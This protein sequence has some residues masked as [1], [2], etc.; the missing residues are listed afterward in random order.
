MMASI[1]L[2]HLPTGAEL[3]LEQAPSC[4]IALGN[5]D[6]VHTA[7]RMLLAAAVRLSKQK[8]DCHSA[9]FFFD[10]PSSQV[11]FTG[12]RLLS[13][14]P[15]KLAIF[16]EA[17]IEY[18]YLAD[19]LSLRN[20]PADPFIE[21]VLL[22]ICHADKVVCGFNFRFGQGGKGNVTLLEQR[23]GTQNIRTLPPCCMPI[24]GHR[25]EHVIS[26]TAVR[27]ALACGDVRA[28]RLLLGRPYRFSAPVLH[29]KQLGR[30]LGIPTINQ[31]PP[32]GKV[33]PT[34][35]VYIT[36]VTIGNE[37]VFGISNVG[38]H[39]TVD[40][41]A[42]Q[43][44]ETHLLNFEG[45]LYGQTI[46]VEFLEMLRQEQKFDSVEQLQKT[47]LGDIEKAKQYFGIE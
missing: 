20:M 3:P 27:N 46:T 38:I 7:H 23:L 5:F 43:N 6:G 28:A 8:A 29:G 34:N 9:V 42:E 2:I 47:I 19:F 13:T 45:D 14:L 17:G 26:S 40:D 36:Q 22:D 10:P 32:L 33:L 12:T 24:P 21:E 44:C 25:A 39:P 37:K 16:A 15:E 18:A 35:G 31:N 30:Q 41:K 11:L 4:V 1:R